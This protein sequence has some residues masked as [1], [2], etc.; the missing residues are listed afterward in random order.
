LQ[1][2]RDSA[3]DQSEY[4]MTRMYASQADN[5]LRAAE[6]VI[7]SLQAFLPPKASV[8]QMYT[9]NLGLAILDVAFFLSASPPST[10]GR[11]NEATHRVSQLG[12]FLE[13]NY[14]NLSAFDD[15]RSYVELM[16]FVEMKHV[17]EKL[18]ENLDSKVNCMTL[19]ASFL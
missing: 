15:I 13:Q 2:P 4:W 16:N 6:T 9:K 17:L 19:P 10:T 18:L 14:A 11:D 8:A 5:F 1:R 3:T 7:A 12:V